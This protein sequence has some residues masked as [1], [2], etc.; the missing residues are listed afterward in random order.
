M[1]ELSDRLTHV[2]SDIR[3]PLYVE[4]LRMQAAGTPVLKLNTGNPGNFGFT[5]PESVRRAL[6]DHVD[7]AVPYCDVRGMAAAREAILAYHQNRGLQGVTMDDIFICNG[8]SESVSMLMTALVGTGD[9]VLVPSPCYSLWS[10]NTYLGGGKPVHYRCDPGNDW[11]PDL[12]DIR[13]KITPRTKA[14]LVINPNNPTGAVYSKQTLLDIAQIAREHH[15][16]LLADEIYDRLVLED[17]P[18]YSIAAL[19]PDLPCVT[20]NGLSKSHIICG[21]RCGW[22]AFSGPEEELAAIKHGVMQLAAM[23]LCGNTLTQLVI[24]AALSDRESTRAM[25]APGGRLYE[26][27][28]ATVEG[29]RKIPGVTQVPNRAAFYLFPG[30]ENGAFDFE[31]DED[32]A[33]KFLHEKHILVIPGRGFDW[34]EDLRFRIVMLPEPER[35]TQAMA[36]LGE[37]LDEHRR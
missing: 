20:F 10:N 30:L 18:T 5:L 32:F 36:Q 28:K 6:L 16:L 25:M 7:E 14:I 27:S 34:F 15:L 19:A 11:N 21:F 3:G 23:R 35:I 8:V 4:A 31:S 24:P 2:H 12:E 22:M 26:Q 37:F 1:I 13:S 9:E 29:L 17:L 33:M